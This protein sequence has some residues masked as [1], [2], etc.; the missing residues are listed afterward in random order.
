MAWGTI[1][2]GVARPIDKTSSASWAGTLNG[3]TAGRVYVI[4]I[5]T[6][7]LSTSDGNTNLHSA[8]SD[9]TGDTWTKAREFTNG[10]GT[11]AT[12]ATVSVWFKRASAN[13]S[14]VMGTLTISG[15]SVTAKAIVGMEITTT[16]TTTIISV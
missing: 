11:A 15:G 12:G 9:A 16:D 14:F 8:Y 13:S 2:G 5:A 3:F 10:Q 6:D 1:T 7:N 4:V